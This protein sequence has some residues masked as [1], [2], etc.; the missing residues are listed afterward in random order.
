MNIFVL[1]IFYRIC[2]EL[3]KSRLGRWLSKDPILFAGGD[4]NLYVYVM[5]DPVNLID[6]T[7]ELAFLPAIGI[8]ALVGGLT[9]IAGEVAFGNNVTL[10]SIGST[11][12]AGA[13]GGAITV[14]TTGSTS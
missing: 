10:G 7:G 6:P 12:L 2:F 4:T 14:A 8:G 5:Q 11:A 9:G 1:C 13:A 3:A